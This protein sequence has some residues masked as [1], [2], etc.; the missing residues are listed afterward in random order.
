MQIH[1]R[2]IEKDFCWFGFVYEN[3]L[4]GFGLHSNESYCSLLPS[5]A[6]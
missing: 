6:A 2:D 3:I 5:F 4:W 1:F